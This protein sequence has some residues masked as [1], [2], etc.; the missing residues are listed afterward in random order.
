MKFLPDWDDSE[1]R[2]FDRT[3]LLASPEPKFYGKFNSSK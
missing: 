1:Q 2:K 3:L